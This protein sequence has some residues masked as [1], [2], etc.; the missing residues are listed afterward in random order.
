M[1]RERGDTPGAPAPVGEV[2][3]LLIAMRNRDPD[4][5]H[6]LLP[7]VYAELHRQ[8]ARMMGR[9]RR[10]HTLQPTALVHE[11]FLK[12]FDQRQAS[13]QNRAHFFAVAARAMREILVD[14][15]RGRAAAKRGGGAIHVSV[16]DATAATQPRG[17]DLI[18]LN[19]ALNRLAAHDEKQ[20]RIVELRFF[21]GLTIEETAEVL[22]RSVAT[23]NREWR[24]AQAWLYRQLA[25]ATP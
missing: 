12:L 9:E 25:A 5:L 23:V 19:E 24:H 21:G 17:V 6:R 13:W 20:S 15:A 1:E 3:L 7:L 8:A 16:E 14:H 2:T 22:G 10:D 4:A 11:A 18:A